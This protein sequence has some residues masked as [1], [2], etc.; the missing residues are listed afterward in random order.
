MKCPFKFT[1]DCIV[2][3]EQILYAKLIRDKTTIVLSYINGDSDIINFD[4]NAQCISIFELFCEAC[5]TYSKQRQINED[6]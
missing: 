2:D 1:A 4:D 6:R 3:L 5:M